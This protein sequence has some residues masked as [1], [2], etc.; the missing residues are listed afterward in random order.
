ML[1]DPDTNTFKQKIWVASLIAHEL[2]HQWFGDLVTPKTWVFN[3]MK[4]GM[5]T[6]FEYHATDLA[7]PEWGILELFNYEVLQN[8]F[9]SDASAATV[10][11]TTEGG[12]PTVI[13]YDKCKIKLKPSQ[14]KLNI[15]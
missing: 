11:M 2:A 3:W 8:A 7:Y 14:F 12:T 5:A 13:T 15:P 9:K 4:E 6:V 10:A 1:F